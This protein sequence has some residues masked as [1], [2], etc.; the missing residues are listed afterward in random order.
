MTVDLSHPFVQGM[1]NR[2]N[3]IEKGYLE[4]EKHG[5]VMTDEQLAELNAALKHCS[6][7]DKSYRPYCLALRCTEMPR[8]FVRAD[9]QGFECP[10]CGN[11][12]GFNL[13]ADTPTP[14]LS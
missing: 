5:Y 7:K 13:R 1:M 6:T 2:M 12:F 3:R 14:K 4:R 11:R 9:G 8:V 10:A